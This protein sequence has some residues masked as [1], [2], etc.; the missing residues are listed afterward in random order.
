MEI[1]NIYGHS[2]VHVSARCNDTGHYLWSFVRGGIN[3]C[4]LQR[5]SFCLTFFTIFAD[6][7]NTD[8]HFVNSAGVSL[9]QRFGVN[10]ETLRT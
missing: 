3:F 10:N 6:S 8:F 7:V 1:N 9:P 4:P 2:K 5:V